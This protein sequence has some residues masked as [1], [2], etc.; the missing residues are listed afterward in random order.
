MEKT[1]KFETVKLIRWQIANMK[2]TI[3]ISFKGYNKEEIKTVLWNFEK[4]TEKLNPEY[5]RENFNNNKECI[6]EIYIIDR[7]SFKNSVE[8]KKFLNKVYKELEKVDLTKTVEEL[9]KEEETIE[10]IKKCII[11]SIK[12]IGGNISK[13]KRDDLKEVAY[14]IC[15]NGIEWTDENIHTAA[16]EL[17]NVSHLLN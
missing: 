9:E 13:Y 12:D 17:I 5:A 15:E 8:E 11:E 4:L 14:M 1:I 6:E 16:V 10:E 7:S 3:K 2:R